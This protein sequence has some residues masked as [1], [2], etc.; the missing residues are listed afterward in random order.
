[1]GL[2]G[3]VGPTL[4]PFRSAGWPT[5]LM[6]VGVTAVGSGP[7]R[8]LMVLFGLC[9]A[10]RGFPQV[11]NTFILIVWTYLGVLGLRMLSAGQHIAILC[12]NLSATRP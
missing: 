8:D 12:P 2:W 3:H 5:L 10:S 7:E 6:L 1:M 11:L 9:G 4:V